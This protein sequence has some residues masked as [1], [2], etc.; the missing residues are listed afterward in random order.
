MILKHLN[1]IPFSPVSHN[2]EIQKQVLLNHQQLPPIT[3]FAQATFPPKAIAPAH[4]HDDMLEVFFV[5]SGEGVMTVN[6]VDHPL[7]A[8]SCISI[9]PKETHELRNASDTE[10]LVVSYFGVSTE[11]STG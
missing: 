1:E 9:E 7:P 3:Q 6:G 4:H 5:Q 10:A 11:T 2:P 8:G